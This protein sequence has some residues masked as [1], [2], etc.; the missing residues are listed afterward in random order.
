MGRPYAYPSPAD[1]GW[2][3]ESDEVWAKDTRFDGRGALVT[4]WLAMT[5]AAM[6]TLL[7]VGMVLHAVGA[8]GVP[9]TGPSRA[10]ASRRADSRARPPPSPADYRLSRER[11][12]MGRT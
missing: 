6:I 8:A 10:L 5:S 4:L 2:F 9:P 11:G 1:P 12:G 7:G 3:R